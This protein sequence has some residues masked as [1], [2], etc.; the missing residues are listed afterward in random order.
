MASVIE[1][2]RKI[3]A[4]FKKELKKKGIV[5]EVKKT[6]G[7][8]RGLFE[9]LEKNELLLEKG[10]DVVD[11]ALYKIELDDALNTTSYGVYQGEPAEEE[12]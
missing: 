12:T 7:G 3:E 6:S 8:W 1:A 10:F 11:R 2:Q 9:A 5:K 4:F